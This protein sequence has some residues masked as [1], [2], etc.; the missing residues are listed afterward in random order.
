MSQ[1]SST[2]HK[3][4]VSEQ[5]MVSVA[6]LTLMVF[7][8]GKLKTYSSNDIWWLFPKKINS[9]LYNFLQEAGR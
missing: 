4:Y 6:L 1:I 8:L 5:H 2:N 7:C 3:E 9:D